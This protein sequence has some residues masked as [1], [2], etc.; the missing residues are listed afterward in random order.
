MVLDEG[1]VTE[2]LRASSKYGNRQLWEVG[3][4]GDLSECARDLG[5][6]TLSGLKGKDIT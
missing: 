1:K 5:G 4:C 3:G 6:E 2:A